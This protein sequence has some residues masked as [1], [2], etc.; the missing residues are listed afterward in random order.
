MTNEQHRE[1]P[2]IY[3]DPPSPGTCHVCGD[4]SRAYIS[5]LRDDEVLARLCV[6]CF[7]AG[8]LWS[9]RRAMSEL[10]GERQPGERI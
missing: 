10:D 3:V 7:S 1:E 5:I 9:A 6:N 8:I 2:V 4:K